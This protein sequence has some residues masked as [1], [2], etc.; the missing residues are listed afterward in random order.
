LH[1]VLANAEI[2]IGKPRA[3]VRNMTETRISQTVVFHRHTARINLVTVV[4]V[5]SH[6]MLHRSAPHP[7]CERTITMFTRISC[8]SQTRAMRCTTAD[9]LQTSKVDAQRDKLAT[10]L[11]WQRLAST[12]ANLQLPHLHLVLPFGTWGWPRLIFA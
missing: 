5:R 11:S 10:E 9:V 6:R 1:T 4:K 7:R 3:A 8:H 2:L 12:V